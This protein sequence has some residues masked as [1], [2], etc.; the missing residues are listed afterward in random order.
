MCGIIG[1]ISEKN[2]IDDKILL[3]MRDSLKH[4]GP[5]NGGIYLSPNEKIGLGHRRLSII[6]LSKNG[7]QPLFSRDQQ[8]VI[9]Y[10]GEVYNYKPLKEKLECHGYNFTTTSDTEVVLN[11]YLKWGKDCVNYFKGM[12]S[13]AIYDIRKNEMF[14]ARDHIGIKPLFYYHYN[15]IFIFA[16]EIKAF[17]LY[18]DLNL[19]INVS[20]LYDYLTYGYIPS[21][22][23]AYKY[24]KKLEPGSFL[25][26]KKGELLN[27][28]YWTL[29]VENSG[30][31]NKK[32]AIDLLSEKLEQAVKNHMVSDVPV[33]LLLSG[34]IDSSTVL[35]FARNRS[36]DKIL[37]FSVGFDNDD[38]SEIEYAELVAKHYDSNHHV[39]NVSSKS[40]QNKLER[41][42][43]LYDEPYAD[44]SAI[45]TLEV[46]AVASDHVKAAL[47]GDGGDEIFCGYLRYADWYNRMNWPSI[48]GFGKYFFNNTFTNNMKGRSIF[49]HLF[50]KND[51]EK[52]GTL[53]EYFS[54]Y[55]KKM[56]RG[57]LFYDKIKE[58][59]DYWFIKKYWKDDLD[60]VKKLQYLDFN[61]YLPEDILTKVDRASMSVSLEVRPALLDKDLVE[62]SFSLPS[63][64]HFNGSLKA[65]IKNSMKNK[66][67]E[68]IINRPKKGFSVPWQSWVQPN[69]K[70]ISNFL[71][72]GK[73]IKS[74]LMN[75]KYL[76][77]NLFR[78][79]GYKIWSL[80][81]LEQ[82]L[83]KE[84]IS[85]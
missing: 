48:K 82:W 52:Y 38:H 62:Y 79:R 5:D 63:N 69:H 11:A 66:L 4:R 68:K 15:N 43:N 27:K 73:L 39:T 18:P 23:T 21:P 2:K 42:L 45:P 60:P 64:Y 13:F 54:P 85:I 58:Y 78:L 36:K 30:S 34:G 49:R 80:L 31:I 84:N 25:I 10:N 70:F 12:F 41:I 35:N 40:V 55:E 83:R 77:K 51:V 3:N 57:E 50:G 26:Y 71:L 6:D 67:P 81:I 61:T 44:S 59:N 17:K 75:E 8:V 22:K 9:V 74:G 32:N 19:E 76:I 28:K 65:L 24:I 33:G 14:I 46:C 47:S 37:T 1:I 20:G 53:I 72:E 16:S 7:N 29:N 56:L